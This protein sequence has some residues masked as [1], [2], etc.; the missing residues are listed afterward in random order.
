[1]WICLSDAFLSVVQ[2]PQSPRRLMVRA[3]ARGDITRVFPQAR[4]H[5]TPQ[6]DYPWRA[7]L[8]RQAVAD[9]VAREVRDIDYTNFKDSVPEDARHDAYTAVWVTMLDWSHGRFRRRPAPAWEPLEQPWADE[10]PC[11]WGKP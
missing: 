10:P 7:Y 9:A 6:R 2:H 8:S 1:M 5:H 4:V 3:R 11:L